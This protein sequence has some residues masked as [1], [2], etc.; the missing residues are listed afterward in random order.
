MNKYD[1]LIEKY[2][3]IFTEPG[4]GPRKIN[5]Y[6]ECGI[7]WYDILEKL[8]DDIY[9][10]QPTIFQVKE[11]FGELRV[12]ASFPQEYSEQGWK[13]IEQASIEASTV[14]ER[15]GKPGKLVNLNRWLMTICDDCLKKIEQ[16]NN[17]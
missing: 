17:K 11:K 16:K 4:R 6:I 7:G 10:M 8:F 12:Y 2:P 15:C 9:A 5:F 13:R 1:Y 14:C 3:D